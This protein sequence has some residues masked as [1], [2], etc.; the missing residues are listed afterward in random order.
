ME[1][2]YIGAAE[3]NP[4]AAA[5]PFLLTLKLIFSFPSSATHGMIVGEPESWVNSTLIA[6]V[7]TP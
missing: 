5:A 3:W 4:P 2:A 1:V 7:N 6:M